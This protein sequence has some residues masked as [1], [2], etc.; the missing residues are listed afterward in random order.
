V[1]G[2]LTKGYFERESMFM[3]L[4]HLLLQF[5]KLLLLCDELSTHFIQPSLI[6]LINHAG[7]NF[8]SIIRRG[9]YSQRKSRGSLNDQVVLS[10]NGLYLG[11][12]LLPGFYPVPN[13][14][15]GHSQLAEVISL[16]FHPTISIFHDLSFK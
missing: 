6:F 1:S 10:V 3:C 2:P 12:G 11:S 8:S 4:G 5:C 16:E 14:L 7:S 9:L 15:I 13:H